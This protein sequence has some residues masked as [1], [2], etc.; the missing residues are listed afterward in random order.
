MR[1]IGSFFTPYINT[2]FSCNHV[3]FHVTSWLI[4]S[5]R[6]VS[7]SPLLLKFPWHNE[8]MWTLTRSLW[9]IPHWMAYRH[10]F[11][12]PNCKREMQ[13]SQ[14]LVRLSF[15]MSNALKVFAI[16]GGTTEEPCL[17]WS[18]IFSKPKSMYVASFGERMWP[19][20]NNPNALT[21]LQVLNGWA[22]F[23]CTKLEHPILRIPL[24][25]NG[26]D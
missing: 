19:K 1:R 7:K 17:I 26:V 5:L 22:T 25:Y 14:C 16:K 20:K 6:E 9:N 24:F 18:L 2:S 21:R 23:D 10:V 4:K 11:D 15:A 13:H 12:K 8:H 3:G